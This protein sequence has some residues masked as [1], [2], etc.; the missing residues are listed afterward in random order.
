M[1]RSEERVWLLPL[2]SFRVKS[3]AGAPS[4]RAVFKLP[5]L[6]VDENSFS[7]QP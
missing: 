3:I 4:A 2:R 7:G 1:A 6:L 5:V